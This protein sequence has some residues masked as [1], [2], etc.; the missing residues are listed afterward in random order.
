MKK[1]I[2]TISPGIGVTAADVRIN[3]CTTQGC[4]PTSVT[5]HPASVATKPNGATSA[6]SSVRC[7]ASGRRRHALHAAHSATSAIALPSPTIVWKARCTTATGG[8]SA[9]GTVRS[10]FTSA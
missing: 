8:R 1:A 6:R 7:V 4:R 5:I 10:P 3:P 2:G 9:G